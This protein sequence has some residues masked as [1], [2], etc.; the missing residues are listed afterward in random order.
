MEDDLRWQTSL[1]QL[2]KALSRLGQALNEPETNPLLVD[3]TIQR[4][5]FTIEL[6]WK[7]FRHLLA[8]EGKESFSPRECL[9]AAYQLGW[10]HD[11]PL[12]WAYSKIAI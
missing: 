12:G 3:A 4:F 7:T 2:E 10:I 6:F 9:K 8:L 1:N 11:E 5:E